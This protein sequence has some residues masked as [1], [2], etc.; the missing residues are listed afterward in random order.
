MKPFTQCYPIC[1]KLYADVGEDEAPQKR[2]GK[3]IPQEFFERRAAHSRGKGNKS[4]N[5]RQKTA[6]KCR[7]LPKTGKK[8]VRDPQIVLGNKQILAVAPD[9][10]AAPVIADPIGKGRT[11][12]APES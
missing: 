6:Y 10:R 8:P 7:Q 2:A 12:A 5:Y 9:Q 3:R 1:T 4:S 11:Y